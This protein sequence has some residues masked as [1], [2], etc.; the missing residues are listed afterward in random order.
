MSKSNRKTEVQSVEAPVPTFNR[1]EFMAQHGNVKSRAIRA[2]YAEGKNVTE[3][4]KALDVKYQHVRNVLMQ[5]IGGK[6]P[7]RDTVVIAPQ[8]KVEAEVEQT[9]AA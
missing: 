2:L 3:I 1:E 7:D 4:A 9:E 8:P 6:L 5:P